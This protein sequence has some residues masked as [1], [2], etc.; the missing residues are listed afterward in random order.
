MSDFVHVGF[1]SYVVVGRIIAVIPAT[2]T[3]ALRL[4]REAKEKGTLVDTT[5]GRKTRSLIVVDT[6]HVILSSQKPGHVVKESEEATNIPLTP[7]EK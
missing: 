3:P 4:K 1:G 6:G 5:N 7:P 2:P